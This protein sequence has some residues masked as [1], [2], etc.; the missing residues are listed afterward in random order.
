MKK[1]INVVGIFLLFLSGVL[2]V[3]PSVGHA[4][5]YQ[6]RLVID[7]KVTDPF[8]PLQIVN[9]RTLMPVI[10]LQKSMGMSVEWDGAKRQVTVKDLGKVCVMT[11]GSTIVYV[12]GVKKTIDTAPIIIGDRT[13]VPFRVLGNL[14]GHI[15]AY[16][17]ATKTVIY[18]RTL[19]FSLNGK[20]IPMKMYKLP[21][22]TYADLF[23][24]NKGLGISYSLNG[25][26]LSLTKGSL[27]VDLPLLTQASGSGGYRCIDGYKVIPLSTVMYLMN[28][29]GQW[30][31]NNFSI[32]TT[33]ST[34][35][36]LPAAGF[37]VVI[38][39][40]HGGLD[41]GCIGADGK[42]Y[43]KNFTLST[44][45]KLKSRLLLNPN[46]KVL[47]TRE[48]DT[49]LSLEERVNVANNVGANVFIS[50]HANAFDNSAANGTESFYYN[51]TSQPFA[52]VI[53]KHLLQAT[54]FQDRG[55]KVESFRVLTQT[56]MP[57]VLIEV[58][59]LTNSSNLAEMNSDSFK[60]N[61]AEELY[62]A[63]LEY[64]NKVNS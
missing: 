59:F 48:G 6:P 60:Q 35:S 63:I 27:H 50:I 56:N 37:T 45:Q 43:E 1:I 7:G 9:N 42:T 38:D 55:L 3:T 17:D 58:G 39:P 14:I 16:E 28:G 21:E 47:M 26:I 12:N 62:Q 33:Q 10:Q 11:I 53:H 2:G 40:G 13:Y 34:S 18:N 30:E 31:G 32:T 36:P 23:S 51:P 20:M 25:N 44:S 24:L 19:G 61:V 5:I 4:A 41:S 57:A 22:S 52:D 15:V 8:V 64:Y 46:F 49:S 54:Q 29:K